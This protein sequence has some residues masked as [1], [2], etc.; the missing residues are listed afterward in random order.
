MKKK[1]ECKD[2]KHGDRNF[3]GYDEC[4]LYNQEPDF[5]V[6]INTA[7]RE[8]TAHHMNGYGYCRHYKRPSIFSRIYDWVEYQWWRIFR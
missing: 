6:T 3:W 5:E 4:W 2:C 7:D 1:K 8:S